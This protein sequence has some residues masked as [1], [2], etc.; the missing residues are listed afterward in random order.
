MYFRNINDNYLLFLL[1]FRL[2]FRGGNYDRNEIYSSHTEVISDA[3]ILVVY[4]LRGALAKNARVSHKMA[5]FVLK[6]V[7][8]AISMEPTPLLEN[9]SSYGLSYP[10]LLLKPH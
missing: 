5:Q 10:N 9:V 7:H 3:S 6:I 4:P 8:L 2:K 1:T